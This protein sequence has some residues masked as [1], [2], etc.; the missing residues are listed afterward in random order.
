MS[1]VVEY[2]GSNAIEHHNGN[3]LDV[4]KYL[5][6]IANSISKTLQNG[7]PIEMIECQQT[8]AGNQVE[9]VVIKSPSQD[10]ARC[11]DCS[12]VNTTTEF[13]VA[14]AGN[15]NKWVPANGGTETVFKS[16][17][18]IRMLYCFNPALGQHQYLNVDTDMIMTDDEA[19][20]AL[21]L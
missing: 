5:L 18:G 15:L 10:I 12:P 11:Y 13:E 14:V 9:V 6:Q 19:R 3:K 21:S 4:A 7:V 1:T 20:S 16:R 8:I 17:S 2:F